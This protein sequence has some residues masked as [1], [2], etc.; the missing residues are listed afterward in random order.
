MTEPNSRTP[1]WLSRLTGQTMQGPVRRYVRLGQPS[2][3][4]RVEI[5]SGLKAGEMIVIAKK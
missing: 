3:D 4:E 2:P 5:I 1:D